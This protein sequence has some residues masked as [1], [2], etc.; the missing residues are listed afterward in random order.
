MIQMQI[1]YLYE[2]IPMRFTGKSYSLQLPG[3]WDFGLFL[4]PIMQ[5]R[6]IGLCSMRFAKMVKLDR[7]HLRHSQKLPIMRFLH[8]S[9]CIIV[10]STV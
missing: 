10:F 7:N 3:E 2:L 8:Y 9:I 6:A 1:L 4:N 5:N